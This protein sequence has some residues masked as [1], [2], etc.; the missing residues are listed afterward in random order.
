MIEHQLVGPLLASTGDR[1][2]DRAMLARCSAGAA[3]WMRRHRT[4]GSE[5][6]DDTEEQWIACQPCD[7]DVKVALAARYSLWTCS[8]VQYPDQS[9]G[10]LFRAVP[11][12]DFC[13]LGFQ[14]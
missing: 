13:R 6:A 9:L 4:V 5:R 8:I 3:F 12:R 10:F 1:V 2:H 7:F 11:G 14:K